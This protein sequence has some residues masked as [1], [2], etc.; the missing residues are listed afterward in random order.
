[1]QIL[2]FRSLTHEISS[3]VESIS[4]LTQIPFSILVKGLSAWRTGRPTIRT[5]ALPPVLP[6][7]AQ[8]LDL[9]N[10]VKKV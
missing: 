2:L 4:V 5:L 10:K 1:M 6:T 9:E 7:H 3:R 8:P